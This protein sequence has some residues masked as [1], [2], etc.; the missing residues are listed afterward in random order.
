MYKKKKGFTLV[1]VSVY[2]SVL[3]IVIVIFIQGFSFLKVIKD[4]I[5]IEK[6]IN[7]IHSFLTL[8]KSMSKEKG[9]KGKIS[10]D[11]E[12]NILL[13]GIIYP[14]NENIEE[15][16]LSESLEN[17]KI[18]SIN[19]KANSLLINENGS[20]TTPCTIAIKDSR[21]VEHK[22]TINIGG[23]TIDIKE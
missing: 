9:V 22:I 14:L 16:I 3:S 4:N 10:Y 19:G 5:I 15:I 11:K 17:V 13:Y 12:E 23:G 18:E 2:L 21:E 6:D 20:I 7:K 8:G 1:E